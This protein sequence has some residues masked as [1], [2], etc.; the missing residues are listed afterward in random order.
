MQLRF[1]SYRWPVNGVGVTSSRR[2][3]RA[4]DGIPWKVADAIKADGY[5][6][7]TGQA[8]LTTK[9]QEMERELGRNFRDLVFERDDGQASAT[10][11][12]N[13]DSIGGVI[14]TD[15]PNFGDVKGP[16]YV[17]QRHFDFTA[18]AE[19][20]AINAPAILEWSESVRI[21]GGGPVFA[22][23]PALFGPPQRQMVYQIEPC[24][25][26]QQGFA[27]GSYGYPTPA[28]PI[29]PFALQRNGQ[30]NRVSPRKVGKA[31]YTEWRIDWTY[32]YQWPLPLF[33]FPTMWPR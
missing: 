22:C 20:R 1:G 4:G 19:Y 29:W 12:S 13:A 21:E 9:Q 10:L 11:L 33:G 23:L 26:T 16:E 7:G 14:I 17:T 32:T 28:P 2:L 6:E 8:D 31:G 18:E 5:L 15:G 27:V 30:F 25:A 3:V 24:V